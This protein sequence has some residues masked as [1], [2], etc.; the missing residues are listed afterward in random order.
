MPGYRGHDGDDAHS[1]DNCKGQE[2]DWF[3]G[4]HEYSPSLTLPG[5]FHLTLV[6]RS[7]E[8]LTGA[9]LMAVS[10]GS[11]PLGK[12]GK[13][14]KAGSLRRDSSGCEASGKVVLL[15]C[16]QI[17]EYEIFWGG[18]VEDVAAAVVAG[19]GGDGVGVAGRGG[20]AGES[21]RRD[22]QFPEI[23]GVA[24]CWVSSLSVDCVGTEPAAMEFAEPA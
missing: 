10:H 6:S 22:L 3:H 21:K 15:S 4:H 17:S 2:N 16:W 1:Q 8:S 24:E 20:D 13:P 9:S 19:R 18:S 11:K 23:P 14:E 5:P 12:A 7:A